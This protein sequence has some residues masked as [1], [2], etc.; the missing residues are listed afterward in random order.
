M[1]VGNKISDQ[2]RQKLPRAKSCDGNKNVSIPLILRFVPKIFTRYGLNLSHWEITAND[3][4][5]KRI[6]LLHL[7]I[8]SKRNLQCARLLHRVELVIY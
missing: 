1:P 8:R 5:A 3:H 7:K 6:P 2:H 4:V